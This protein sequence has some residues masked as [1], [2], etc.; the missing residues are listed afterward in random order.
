MVL[1]QSQIIPLIRKFELAGP[2]KEVS[3]DSSVDV[4][5]TIKDSTVKEIVAKVRQFRCLVLS[6]YHWKF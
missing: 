5:A 6:N 3:V 2:A 1:P 4:M